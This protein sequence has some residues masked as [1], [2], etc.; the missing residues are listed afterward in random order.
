MLRLIGGAAKT[1]F[2]ADAEGQDLGNLNGRLAAVDLLDLYLG[3][4]GKGRTKC[5]VQ[6]CGALMRGKFLLEPSR[7]D[8]ISLRVDRALNLLLDIDR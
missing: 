5:N 7:D 8:N 2:D 1:D 6:R 4:G 3:Y